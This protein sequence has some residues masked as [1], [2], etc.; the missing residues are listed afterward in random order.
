MKFKR[1]IT[2]ERGLQPIDIVPLIDLLF[3]LLI[4]FM[5]STSFT[6]Q[7]NINVKLPK[8]VTSDMIKEENLVITIT[9]ENV[10]YLNNTVT[11]LKELE[12]TLTKLKSKNHQLLIKTDRRTSVGR[13]V[14]VWDL[15]RKIGLDHINIATNQD[16]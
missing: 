10:V 15:C 5:V 16:N 8:A 7:S 3:L 13:I 11:T 1:Q 12:N 9:S 14:D 4:F 6:F 2:I